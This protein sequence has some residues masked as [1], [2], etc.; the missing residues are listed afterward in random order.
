MKPEVIFVDVKD[1]MVTMSKENLQGLID[2]AYEA[3]KMDAFTVNYI[4]KPDDHVYK[5]TPT[6]KPNTAVCT[7]TGS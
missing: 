6:W 3:G 5:T 2:R 1:G 4:R 7:S